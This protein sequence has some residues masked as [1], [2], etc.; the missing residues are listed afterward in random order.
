MRALLAVS[1]VAIV[2]TVPAVSVGGKAGGGPTVNV[3]DNAFVRSVNRPTVKIRKGG[4]VTWRWA[5]RQSHGVS[6][7]SGPQKF[8]IAVRTGGRVTRRFAKPGTYRI[9]CQLHAPG[10][11]MTVVVGR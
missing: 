8:T 4:S 9:V 7:R 10:M 11:K 6:V 3:T 2:L 1:V 5:S